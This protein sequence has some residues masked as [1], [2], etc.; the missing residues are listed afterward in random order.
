MNI[1]QR[2]AAST[3]SSSI[4][5]VNAET[6]AEIVSQQRDA[7]TFNIAFN[8]SLNNVNKKIA[9]YDKVVITV[10]KKESRANAATSIHSNTSSAVSGKKPNGTPSPSVRSLKP[11][12]GKQMKIL[13]SKLSDKLYAGL[14]LIKD[15]ESKEDYV[16][17]VTVNISPH[18]VDAT[19]NL[20]TYTELFA[21]SYKT[22]PKLQR[23]R[24]NNLRLS[25]SPST[26]KTSLKQTDSHKID[27]KN[28]IEKINSDLVDITSPVYDHR[29]SG[30]T[31]VSHLEDPSIRQRL[32]TQGVK[33]LALD[34]S[35]YYLD[36]VP[37]SLKEASMKWYDQRIVTKALDA[38][39][40]TEKVSIK[41][42][43]QTLVLT[44]KFDL[45]KRGKNTVEETVSTDLFVSNHV[46]AFNVFKEHPEIRVNSSPIST[47]S[48]H[49]K[50]HT[51]SIF[52]KEQPGKTKGFN[53]YLK[54]IAQNGTASPYVKIATIPNRRG[55]NKYQF[56]TIT[57]LSVLRVVP[58]DVQNKESNLYASEVLGPGHKSMGSLTILPRHMG[59]NRVRVDVFNIPKQTASL[60]LYRR[61]CTSNPDEKFSAYVTT[62]KQTTS[63]YVFSD[64][65]AQENHTY[66]YYAV[67]TVFGATTATAVPLISNY[68]MFKNT[69]SADTTRS[70][71]VELSGVT[72]QV[73]DT[74]EASVSFGLK[75][76]V[77]PSESAL[78]TETLKTQYPEIYSQY[79]DPANNSSSPLGSTKGIP[80]YSD[81]FMHEIVRTNLNTAEREFF[82]LVSDGAFNDNYT[83]QKIN[84]VKP[85]NPQHVYFY[86]VFTYKKNP[87]EIFKNFVA[88]GVNSRGKEWFY[89]PYKWKNVSA[90][91]GK[92]Y[93]DDENGV[94]VIDTYELLTSEAF[95]LT[96]TYQTEGSTQ[97]T[98]LSQIDANRIDRN[99]VKIVWNFQNK[100]QNKRLDL[101]DCFVVLKVVNGVRSFV[102]RT[103]K[104]YIYHELT[105]EDLGTIYYI[106]VPIMSEFDIDN[107]GFSSPLLIT[108][109][110]IAPKIK[111]SNFKNSIQKTTN[112]PTVAQSSTQV[113]S[114]QQKQVSYSLK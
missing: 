20:Y 7:Y 52:D 61:D 2:K 65:K 113:L 82:S 76:T 41:K 29:L 63:Q 112:R 18:V 100:S 107:A 27:P 16:D 94:P 74:G 60:T 111:A 64:E 25:G 39:E 3:S 69:P 86:Q 77:S 42:S 73:A 21:P 108:P 114:G 49:K 89:L 78:I 37:E 58:F 67:A 23:N 88:R 75:T 13:P 44:V 99:T 98:E 46:E 47:Q 22:D 36:Y 10:K 26:N 97:F 80:V 105:S 48:T 102:G 110:G 90:I 51:V 101:Y 8:L 104:N 6:F 45:Y 103:S 40:I 43:N 55:E 32:I 34:M 72:T 66:E 57:D 4:L 19:T 93:A 12:N 59:K 84:N 106:V 24:L 17:K 87:I 1:K 70:I 28:T 92:L 30:L 79:L 15:I 50:T 91:N 53:V 96:A 54:S 83:S 95:G 5:S 14:Q 38:V 62:T 71:S 11:N 81:L 33:S 85:I 35:K 9:D 31:S 68:A 109:E 56:E